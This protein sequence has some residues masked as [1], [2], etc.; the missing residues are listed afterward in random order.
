MS[1][2][3]RQLSMTFEARGVNVPALKDVSFR[4]EA[5][6]FV[7]IV[8]PSGCGKTTLLRLLSGLLAPT[9]G[10]IIFGGGDGP[11]RP[12]AALVFQ[13]HALFPW[14]TMLD[15]VAFGLEMQGMGR[16]E[17]LQLAQGIADEMGLGPFARNYPH[18]LSVGMQQRANLARA[19]LTYP[20]ILL[21]DEP[22]G[23]LDAQT[24][25]LLQQ[26]LLRIWKESRKLVVYVTHDIREAVLLGDRVLVMSG[27]PGTIREDIRVPLGRPRDL[28]CTDT[29]EAMAIV[30]HIWAAIEDEVRSALWLKSETADAGSDGAT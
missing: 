22:L 11:G 9:A 13:Q 5:H 19:F 30:R 7:C 27:R 12:H 3:C 18:E 10:E 4:V 15:N 2:E 24:K 21:M 6:E 8:G 17:R 26:E 25:L 28:T 14:L 20:E 23:S 29:P 1:F 16:R